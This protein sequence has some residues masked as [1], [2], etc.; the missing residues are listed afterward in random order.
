MTELSHVLGEPHQ[1]IPTAFWVRL[2][3]PAKHDRDLDLR[4]LVQKALDVAFLCVVVV[5]PDLRPELDLL[6]VDLRLVLARELGSLLL[7]VPVLPPVHDLGDRGIGVRCH[8]DQVEIPGVRVLAGFLRRL[9]PELLAA[10]ADQPDL[11]RSDRVVDA[12]LRLRRQTVGGPWASPRP[13]RAITKLAS[14]LSLEQQKPLHAAAQDP[15]RFDSVEP[16]LSSIA[17]EVRNVGAPASQNHRVASSDLSAWRLKFACSPP[18]FRTASDSF[19]S[20]S[21]KTITYG[22]FSSSASRI[23]R[24]TVSSRS[25]TSAR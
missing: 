16:S 3:A 14:I 2:L 24:P 20:L 23:R 18:C 13:Q 10:F 1:Q 15:R 21:P 12:V 19:D 9:D 25:S 8:L 7:L 17:R 22:I 6:D 4:A 11:R 5:D